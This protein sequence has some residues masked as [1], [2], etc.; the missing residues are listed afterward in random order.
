MDINVRVMDPILSTHAQGYRHPENVGH[1]LFPVVPVTA[2]G[3]QVIEF[4]REDFVLYNT[5]R[6]PGE[7]TKSIQYG[8]LGKPYAL[9]NHALD[10]K[11]PREL[12]RDARQ[13]PGI[14]LQTRGVNRTLKN[15]HLGLEYE[16]AQL[17]RNLNSY[18]VS[19][20]ITLAGT[21]QF[22]D[23]ANSDPGGVVQDGINAIEDK[24]VVSPNVMVIGRQVMAKLK[25]H[26]K[27]IEKIKY[28]QK[29]VLTVELLAEFFDIK[30]VVVGKAK[31]M[32]NGVMVDVWGKD[33]IMAYANQTPNGSEEP[34]FGY[35]YTMQEEGNLHPLVEETYYE[36]SNKSWINPICYERA[37]VLS[38]I[39][40]GYLI[41]NAVA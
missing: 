14:D 5:A 15:M 22:N 1:L 3:G 13:V 31:V 32:I 37:P 39:E 38:G 19:N 40:S 18:P 21:D 7:N 12:L 36:R 4:G 17:A 23:Y 30:T 34:S 26:P 11:V 28:S 6:A 9:S 8:H 20:R 25:E 33:I 10:A 35:T 2:A 27:L 24:A 29:G 41:Q 16:Q